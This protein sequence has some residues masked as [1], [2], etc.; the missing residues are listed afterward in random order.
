MAHLITFRELATWTQ[1][2]V[3]AVTADPFAEEVLDKVSGLVRF[4]S[5]HPE[6]EPETVPFDARLVALVV[7]KRSYANPDQE[8]A[9]G[10]GPISGRVLDVAAML[11]DLTDTERATLILY[12]A[13]GDPSAAGGGLWIQRVTSPPEVLLETVLYVG[14]NQ[15][16]NLETTNA[17]PEWMIPMFNPGDPG[18]PNNYPDEG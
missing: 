18:D 12:N 17:A 13:N 14:D 15:Q 3:D 10:V 1:N 7:A 16:I 4:V 9:S 6:W 5:G 2:D 8:V 11:L